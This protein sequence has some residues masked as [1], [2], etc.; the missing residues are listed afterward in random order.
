LE[1]RREIAEWLEAPT[2]KGEYWFS[3]FVEGRYIHP[4]IISVIDYGRPDR[5]LEVQDDFPHETIPVRIFV[6]EYY[7][8]AKWMLIREPDWQVLS[9]EV[10]HVD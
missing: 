2:E 3:P 9:G 6:K 8:K 7:P 10:N 1:T 5:G 4:R